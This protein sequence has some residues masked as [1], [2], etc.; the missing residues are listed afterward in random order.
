MNLENVLYVYKVAGVKKIV[1]GDTLDLVVDLG[2]TISTLQRFRMCGYDAPETFR[3]KSE[4]EH[5]KGIRVTQKLCELVTLYLGKGNLYVKSLKMG[6]YARYEAWLGYLG[7][8]GEFHW[9]NDEIIAFMKE[10]GLT[11]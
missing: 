9:I 6:A 1:D 7:D 3:P 11:K 8:D 4:E 5:E 10:N 2:F